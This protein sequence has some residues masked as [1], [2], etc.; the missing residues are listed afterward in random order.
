MSILPILGDD[1]DRKQICFNDPPFSYELIRG[2][3]QGGQQGHQLSRHLTDPSITLKVG[4]LSFMRIKARDGA[5]G[6]DHLLE[7][8]AIVGLHHRL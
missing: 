3:Q 7:I 1:K 5:L 6:Y 2:G 4:P 8:G